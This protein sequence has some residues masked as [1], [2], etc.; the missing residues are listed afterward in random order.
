MKENVRD[1]C[2]GIAWGAGFDLLQPSANDGTLENILR[3]PIF[4]TLFWGGGMVVS[5][6]DYKRSAKSAGLFYTGQV[7]GQVGLAATKILY[8]I[9]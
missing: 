5:S 6:G 9:S 8:H 4:S 3:D 1:L 7:V 2:I